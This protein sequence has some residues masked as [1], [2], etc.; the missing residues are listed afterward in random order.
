MRHFLDKNLLVKNFQQNVQ[1]P[2]Q[3][4]VLVYGTTNKSILTK[5]Q[6]PFFSQSSFSK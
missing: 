3:Y 1:T 5:L 4:G 2:Y 6:R